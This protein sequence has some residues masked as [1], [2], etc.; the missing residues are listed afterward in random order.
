M[1]KIL[2][3]AMASNSQLG[4]YSSAEK[5]LNLPLAIVEAINTVLFSHAVSLI[6]K[7]EK[8]KASL[9]FNRSLAVV[10]WFCLGSCVGII[11]ISDY[12]VPVYFG[13]GF[14]PVSTL[15]KIGVLFVFLRG[16]RSVI[17]MQILL[18]RKMD[19]LFNATILVGALVNLCLDL[20]LIPFFG[21]FGAILGTIISDLASGLM[22]VIGCKKYIDFKNAFISFLLF[23]LG[24]GIMYASIYLFQKFAPLSQLWMLVSSVLV[25]GA[26]YLLMTVLAF[27]FLSKGHLITYFKE[28]KKKG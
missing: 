18:P 23:G 24:S 16:I 25:G 20:I 12:L 17:K 5:I 2:L 27:E 21:A 14:E 22:C 15:M 13:D 6:T 19:R 26:V 7:G 1:D 28:L 10:L 4:Y 3:G 9:I 8:E 11:A